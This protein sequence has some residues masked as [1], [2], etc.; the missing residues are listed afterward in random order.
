MRQLVQ[1]LLIVLALLTAWTGAARAADPKPVTV[2]ATTASESSLTYSPQ[3]PEPPNTGAMLLRLGLGTVF[4]LVLCVGSLWLAKPWLQ[5]LQSSG[6]NSQALRIEGSVTLGNR[7]VLYL[8]KVGDTQLV[9]GTDP[10]GL[11]S[12]TVLPASFKEVLDEQVPDDSL[13]V[14]QVMPLVAPE[15][16]DRRLRASVGHQGT[17]HE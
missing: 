12:L 9:A 5:K 2:A 14:E 13:P 4:V 8:I 7:A 10:S 1:L 16:F 6:T 17:L 15:N 11:K 3:W